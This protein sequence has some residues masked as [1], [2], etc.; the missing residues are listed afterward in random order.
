MLR[1][2]WRAILHVGD[3]DLDVYQVLKQLVSFQ[4]LSEPQV[5]HLQLYP[6]A[7]P[8]K[9]L[10][11]AC[12][13]I[14]PLQGMM[15]CLSVLRRVSLGGIPGSMMHQRDAQSLD[16]SELP[17]CQQLISGYWE[18]SDTLHSVD[19]RKEEASE[20]SN[21]LRNATYLRCSKDAK[22]L[23]VS[24]IL[25]ADQIKPPVLINLGAEDLRVPHR[26]DV[27]STTPSRHGDEPSDQASDAVTR[28][29]LLAVSR[30]E[31]GAWLHAV[32]NSSLGLRMDN[33]TVRVAVG[34]RLGVA[35]CSPHSC[36]H[37]GAT[38][39]Q[40]GLHGLSCRFSTGR[41]YRHA[42][43]NE[44]IHRA[45]TTSHI[46]S[47]LEPT[48]L[49]RSDGKRPDGITMVPWK[50]GNLL[51]WDAT[52]SDTYAPSHMA[53][54]TLA[55][56]AVASQAEDRKKIKYSYLDGHP[57]ICFTPIA[58]ETSGVV[59]PLSQI[60]LK[61][62]GHRLSATTGDTKSYSYLLQRLSV[63]VQRGNAASILGTLFHLILLI[64]KMA[65]A[66]VAHLNYS[67]DAG[68]LPARKRKSDIE[69]DTA[70]VV[71]EVMLY[72]IHEEGVE[73]PRCSNCF[74]P[75]ADE[76]QLLKPVDV[77]KGMSKSMLMEYGSEMRC[78]CSNLD[79]S[80]E[81]FYVTYRTVVEN[82]LG[83]DLNWG[84]IVSLMTFTGLLA[85]FLI[86]RG[87]ER[88]KSIRLVQKEQSTVG[89]RDG[90]SLWFAAPIAAL[91]LGMAVVT[92]FLR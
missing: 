48:G 25:L 3:A 26:R 21:Q 28:A 34:L 38:V 70:V 8:S 89:A 37:C 68:A 17:L 90:S 22:M 23:A 78:L 32:P 67:I 91:G 12:P 4:P 45:L 27:S 42:A 29:R 10:S 43:L 18:A 62:L 30:K 36:Q 54:S 73:I 15:I 82:T 75:K 58:Y 44:I 31:S 72:V 7:T 74:A 69:A 80:D 63:A 14:E 57:G 92:A 59:G 11:V 84:R 47:R 79:V 1:P 35:L 60:F 52:C 40:F 77:L 66:S 64:F 41:H 49:D 6:H 33:E 86:Q 88:K 9:Q 56:G 16:T 55:A 61:E 76:P 71:R 2:S 46:P 24:P 65:S 20:R 19:R 51:V 39:D 13:A 53:Q 5:P 81:H 87:Q 85:A 50:N 83:S